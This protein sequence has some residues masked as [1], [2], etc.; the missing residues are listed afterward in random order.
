MDGNN[1]VGRSGHT[2]RKLENKHAIRHDTLPF[3][4]LGRGSD[5]QT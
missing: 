3:E 2:T 5:A 4:C 1:R